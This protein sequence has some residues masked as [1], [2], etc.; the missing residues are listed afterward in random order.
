[1]AFAKSISASEH[2]A[3]KH[4]QTFTLVNYAIL[5]CRLTGLYK[6]MCRGNYTKVVAVLNDTL[7]SIRGAVSCQCTS[8]FMDFIITQLYHML[9]DMAFRRYSAVHERLRDVHFIIV[10]ILTPEVEEETIEWDDIPIGPS[11]PCV[12]VEAYS[13]M[14]PLV[15][16]VVADWDRIEM[17]AI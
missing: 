15:E 1:M 6:L 16:D 4:P 14:P 9:V 3:A 2:F 5:D 17:I 7:R 8:K 13:S 12:S 11:S 10:D